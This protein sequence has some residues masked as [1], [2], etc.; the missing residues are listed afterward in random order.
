[1]QENSNGGEG[2]NLRIAGISLQAIGSRLVALVWLLSGAGAT[3]GDRA[4]VQLIG[5]G[6]ILLGIAL[7]RWPAVARWPV[8][9]VG[10][11][12]VAFPVFQITYTSDTL[13]S[14]SIVWLVLPVVGYVLL[15]FGTV[16][17][18]RLGLGVLLILAYVP[19]LR[20]MNTKS[21]LSAED[22]A[23]RVDALSGKIAP[24]LTS[25][26]VVLPQGMDVPNMPDGEPAIAAYPVL[27]VAPTGKW[28]HSR[29]PDDATSAA[30]ELA[31][32]VMQADRSEAPKL[33]L[34]AAGG[35]YVRE[36]GMLL[37]QLP[38]ARVFLLARIPQLGFGNVPPPGA[39][40]VPPRLAGAKTGGETAAIVADEIGRRALPCIPLAKRL[41]QVWNDS[42]EH[43]AQLIADSLDKGL[44][45]CQCGR[46]DIDALEYVV[47]VT[48]R[49]GFEYFA[50][51]VPDDGRG[52]LRIPGDPTLT[53]DE[54]IKRL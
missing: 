47:L 19:A 25:S 39:R 16:T 13:A 15:L 46:V 29:L 32:R 31:S 49:S 42:G 8:V 10:V 50:Y 2:N 33:Y 53:V 3:L 12:L 30:S 38:L 28:F 36:I 14:T 48:Y 45:E 21:H 34:A 23:K 11:A 18:L 35:E 17:R 4:S 51:P 1:M 9:A 41:E 43:R 27:V 37:G 20:S 6:K 54:W 24:Y 22:C 5:V 44:R 7:V 26:A 40:G 52:L